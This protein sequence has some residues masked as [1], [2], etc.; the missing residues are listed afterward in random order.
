MFE[1]SLP[2]I[3]N[4]FVDLRQELWRSSKNGSES[5]TAA[6]S[7]EAVRRVLISDIL[8]SI[9]RHGPLPSMGW[10][11]SHLSLS[12]LSS[13]SCNS[14]SIGSGVVDLQHPI[15]GI[16]YRQVK[17]RCMSRAYCARAGTEV[18]IK[19]IRVSFFATLLC[20]FEDEGAISNDTVP[21]NKT[22]PGDSLAKVQK[23]PFLLCIDEI[24][25]KGT[26]NVS[27]VR[28]LRHLAG[29]SRQNF[30]RGTLVDAGKDV[31]DS[32]GYQLTDQEG[33][34][35]SFVRSSGGPYIR[36]GTHIEYTGT[37]SNTAAKG[38]HLHVLCE[39]VIPEKGI[40][41][42]GPVTIRV[43]ESE[44][45]TREFVRT[46][47]SDG[48]RSDWGPIFLH[49][50]P[51]ASNKQQTA[52]SGTM[53]TDTKQTLAGKKKAR[54]TGDVAF[55]DK[56]LHV[57][58]YQAIELARLTNRSPLLWLKV[59]PD[60]VFGGM[61]KISVFQMDAC[62]AEQLFNDADSASQ[63]EAL[64]TL[65]ERPFRIQGGVKVTNVYV[66]IC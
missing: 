10:K 55:N 28:T 9:E 39:P 38:T 43:V 25:K 14:T 44:G 47:S 41:F 8:E 60:G 48:S 40:S 26:T 16:V 65:A 19:A 2:L 21:M 30:L 1:S 5:R 36:V 15:G 22:K 18:F 63:I 3:L 27:F 56:Q 17:A 51:V 37:D 58:G 53:D 11:N 46:L 20:E 66:S 62:V 32:S 33:F 13:N 23:A 6:Q 35:N 24:V 61:G 50:K 42:G 52:A 49:A 59:D 12:F 45:Q 34:P 4:L 7:E 64:R 57:E 29:I 31:R 54:L